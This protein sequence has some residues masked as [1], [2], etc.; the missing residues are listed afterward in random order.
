V[1]ALVAAF[2][3]YWFILRDDGTGPVTAGRAKN[4]EQAVRGYLEALASGHASDALAFAGTPPDDTT[5]LTDAVLADSLS[6]NPITGIQVTTSSTSRASATVTATYSIGQ[7]SVTAY[8]HVS[9]VGGYYLL[10]AAADQV[11]LSALQTPNV[12]LM[13]DDTAVHSPAVSLFP[14]VY[15]LGVNNPMLTVERG[16]FMVECPTCTVET[17]TSASVGISPAG[18]TILQQAAQT[19]LDNCLAQQTFQTTCGF[20]PTP[21]APYPGATVV[22][23]TFVWTSELTDFSSVGFAFDATTGH[24]ARNGVGFSVSVTAQESLGT[25]QG[26]IGGTQYLNAI[27]IDFSDPNNLVVTFVLA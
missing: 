8:Y 9:R 16:Q 7:Y 1:I 24:V 22:P 10:D 14:G 19:Q 3:V 17:L 26:T 21:V 27:V 13:L 23:D 15:Q 25:W 20:L 4:P 18:Q 12:G 5:F 11:D 6:T 2:G